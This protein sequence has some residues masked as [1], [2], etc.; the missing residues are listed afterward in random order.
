MGDRC[1]SSAV[2][3]LLIWQQLKQ[4]ATEAKHET[5]PGDKN[6]MTNIQSD[7][8]MTTPRVEGAGA[9]CHYRLQVLSL[10]RMVKPVD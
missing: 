8:S 2:L 3:C 10:V 4:T 5:Q 7:G 1:E 6:T 9:S